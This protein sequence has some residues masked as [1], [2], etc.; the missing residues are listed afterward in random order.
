MTGERSMNHVFGVAAL[1]LGVGLAIGFWQG[2]S[3]A[4]DQFARWIRAADLPAGCTRLLYEA[5][6]ALNAEAEDR[7]RAGE[8]R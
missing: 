2:S 1:A 7:M 5:T 8:G 6:D 4:E 3:Q